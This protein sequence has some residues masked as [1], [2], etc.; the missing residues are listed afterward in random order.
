MSDAKDAPFLVAAVQASSVFLDREATVDKACALIAEAGARGARLVAFPEGFI[1][2]YPFWVWFIPAGNTHALRE[3]YAEL[4]DQAVTVPSPATDRLCAAAREAG[5]NVAVGINERNAEAS[6]STLYNSL[7]YISADGRILGCHRKLVPTAGERLVHAPGDGSTLAAYDLD[8]GRA[9]GLICWEN[10][11]PLARYAMYAWGVQLYVAPT[12]DRGEPWISTL[13]H[14]AKEGR[15]YVL[16]CC[17]AVRRA[18]VPDRFPFKEKFLLDS[19]WINPGDSTIID[20]DGKFLV[21]PV[22]N[23]EEILYAEVDPRQLRGPR[24]QLDVAGHYGRPDVF[25]LTVHRE[26][27]PMIREG[28]EGEKS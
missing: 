23:R 28:K 6:G 4:L 18:D 12:W 19:E 15:V 3:L 21:E 1:P 5:V 10:Y 25:E 20:P 26:P 7:L 11:M 2:A 9:G 8:V 22:K 27:R 16:G 17:S 14:I 13:R 24:W